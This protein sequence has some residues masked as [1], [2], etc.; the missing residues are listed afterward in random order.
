MAVI[1]KYLRIIILL[2]FAFTFPSC[3]FKWGKEED[4][5][6]DW[7]KKID[8]PEIVHAIQNYLAY[9]RH[10][11]HLRLEDSSVYYDDYI[12]AIRMEFISQDIME[13]REARMLLVDV[14]EGLLAE[15]NKNPVLGPEFITYP[16]TPRQLEIYINFESYYGIYGD[17]YYVGWMKLEKDT[18]YFYAFDLKY[19]GLNVWDYR[20]EP[21]FKSREFVV[22][23]RESEQLFKQSVEMEE[24]TPN[25]LKKEQYLPV[26]RCLPRYFSPYA[27]EPLFK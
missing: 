6:N 15:L 23:E 20:I 8:A 25:Y 19:P 4:N 1:I 9:L 27:C 2:T 12:N 24:N 16:L 21:Y 3:G 5:S 11:K 17:P 10:E 7:V 26:E 18:S 14:V 13:V 22:Y